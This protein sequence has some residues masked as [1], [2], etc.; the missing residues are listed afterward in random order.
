MTYEIGLLSWM[1][2]MWLKLSLHRLER[3]LEALIIE[4]IREAFLSIVT[5]FATVFLMGIQ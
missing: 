5:I 3:A 2:S 4:D 1:Q